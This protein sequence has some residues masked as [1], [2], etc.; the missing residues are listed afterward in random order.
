MT[1]S[2]KFKD[3]LTQETV[4]KIRELDRADWGGYI[5]GEYHCCPIGAA[6]MVTGGFLSNPSLSYIENVI[7]LRFPKS[8]GKQM[9]KMA[10]QF[11]SRSAEERLEMDW[12]EYEFEQ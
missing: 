10:I 3:V 11:D 2:K 7:E 6:I 5:F 8:D 1:R 9:K 12:L 4:D